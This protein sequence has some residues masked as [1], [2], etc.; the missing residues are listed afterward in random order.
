MKLFWLLLFA[1]F[2]PV[3][4]A[5]WVSEDPVQVDFYL[6]NVSPQIIEPGETT[7][8]NIT[9]KN[10]APAMAVDMNAT[11]DPD[12]VSP[13]DAVGIKK[14]HVDSVAKADK[15]DVFLGVI[16]RE[17]IEL[18]IPVH[19]N[20]D[21]PEGV[22]QVPLVLYWEDIIRKHWTQTLNMGIHIKGNA[23]VRVAKITT[24]PVEL[25]PDTEKNE[26]II[27]VEN[28]GKTVAK[29]VKVNVVPESPFTES[30]S[31]SSSD[32]VANI[33][34]DGSHDFKVTLDLDKDALAG[35]Y[36][37]PLKITYRTHEKEYEINDELDIRISSKA[38][39]EV[40]NVTSSPATIHPGD[41]Y[42]VN[43]QIKNIGQERAENVKAV[44]RT[45]SYFTGVKT[46]YLGDI[47]A[48]ESRLATFEL[49]A[50]R[51][52]IP[53]NYEN[54]I[55]LIW[56]E[57]NDRLEDTTSFGITISGDKDD[58]GISTGASMVIIV[59]LGITGYVIWRKMK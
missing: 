8:L 56:N 38:V 17:K 52:T 53:D 43:I 10:L 25:R 13:V 19:V 47:K 16:Q 28:A 9:L 4:S 48:G 42:I 36:T 58:E 27:K 3:S 15:S 29:S 2:I 40:E 6:I 11:L 55:N 1:I 12:D 24:S 39:F 20:K 45:R 26:F 51:D 18:S 5:I 35:Q 23:V 57:G 44:I 22:Y 34:V 37:L 31:G 49:K 50:D 41:D 59:L 7:L 32:F 30:Y 46:D 14:I 21:T 54:D 33:S